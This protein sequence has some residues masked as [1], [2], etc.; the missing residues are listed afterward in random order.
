[1]NDT[2]LKKFTKALKPENQ[3]TKATSNN[4]TRVRFVSK[5][6]RDIFCHTKICERQKYANSL[7]IRRRSYVNLFTVL[8]GKYLTS[9]CNFTFNNRNCY[10]LYFSFYNSNAK[11][12]SFFLI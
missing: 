11:F 8:L 10:L 2:R 9:A 1:M 5:A 7:I 6:I 3:Y 4:D 12:R